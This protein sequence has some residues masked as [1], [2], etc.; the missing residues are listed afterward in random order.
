MS[1]QEFRAEVLRRLNGIDGRLE[2]GTAVKQ[3]TVAIV[4]V[5]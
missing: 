2:S 3:E 5:A 4:S 1:E